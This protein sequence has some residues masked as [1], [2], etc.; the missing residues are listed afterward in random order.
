MKDD[1]EINTNV[2]Q[3]CVR[4]CVCKLFFLIL[5]ILLFYY[6]SIWTL[7]NLPIDFNFSGIALSINQLLL[8]F[9]FAFRGH[10]TTSILISHTSAVCVCVLPLDYDF[11][12]KLK[13][14]CSYNN[15]AK[16]P[17]T[18]P[19]PFG[20]TVVGNRWPTL[21]I[22]CSSDGSLDYLCPKTAQLLCLRTGNGRTKRIHGN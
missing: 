18:P 2:Q 8:L 20:R 5:G 16:P 3:I 10:L 9:G 14:K 12:V 11:W 22:L 6:D 13:W 7:F 4:V 15:R 17:P 19:P 1:C 21:W